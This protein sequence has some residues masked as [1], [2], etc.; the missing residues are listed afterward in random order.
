M[1]FDLKNMFRIGRALPVP[2]ADSSKS[3]VRGSRYGE[4]LILP[5]VNTKH[6]LADEGAYFTA[7]NPTISTPITKAASI[8]A[9]SDT[10]G[11][12]VIKNN[13]SPSNPKAKRVYLD[14]IRLW[15]AGTAPATTTV[16]GW[17]FKIDN[18]DRFPTTAANMT[19]LTP[20]NVNMDDNTGS[21][22]KLASYANAGAMTIPASSTSAR[23]AARARICTSLGITGD[24]YMVQFGKWNVQPIQGLAADRATSV[25]QLVAHAAP[26]VIGPQQ[27]L[28]AHMWW[29]TATTNV[30]SFEFEL[31]WWER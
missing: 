12:F 3:E 27:T 17:A 18:V 24:E 10:N 16:M 20:A 26:V 22:V 2:V 21:V 1:N 25:A 23:V 19:L 31:G 14:F 7:T 5:V 9:F 6:N 28:V 15:L 29:L 4:G 30:E 13:D 11:T 8:V